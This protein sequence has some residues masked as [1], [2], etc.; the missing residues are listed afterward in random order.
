MKSRIIILVLVMSVFL[1][2]SCRD[3]WVQ[4]VNAIIESER[5]SFGYQEQF[6]LIDLGVLGEK[7]RTQLGDSNYLKHGSAIADMV[8]QAFPCVSCYVIVVALGLLD[9]YIAK[10]KPALARLI[11]QALAQGKSLADLFFITLINENSYAKMFSQ[12]ILE[13]NALSLKEKTKFINDSITQVLLDDELYTYMFT[14]A[15]DSKLLTSTTLQNLLL[16]F[17]QYANNV[18]IPRAQELLAYIADNNM[19]R[20]VFAQPLVEVMSF[21]TTEYD[22]AELQSEDYYIQRVLS[23]IFPVIYENENRSLPQLRNL[24]R[25]DILLSDYCLAP[26]IFVSS[27]YIGNLLKYFVIEG[28]FASGGY[29]L[30]NYYVDSEKPLNIGDRKELVYKFFNYIKSK[31]PS[32]YKTMKFQRI[33][34]E[35]RHMNVMR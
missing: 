17:A 14:Y 16:L 20:S 15:Q 29:N 13:S 19:Q 6:Y 30:K 12:I 24:D 33:E 2:A 23:A 31:Y 34:S 22:K 3:N 28:Y 4:Q 21:K 18:Y 9:S 25:L 5:A 7:L 26:F 32:L 11:N 1:N 10:H 27:A 35:I 8:C